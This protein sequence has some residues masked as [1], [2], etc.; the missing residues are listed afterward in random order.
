[1]FLI[2]YIFVSTRA[3]EKS[4]FPIPISQ[5]DQHSSLSFANYDEQFSVGSFANENPVKN[6]KAAF[7]HC[8]C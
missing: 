5:P 8:F 6:V 1:M 3:S 7:Y 2:K 4:L